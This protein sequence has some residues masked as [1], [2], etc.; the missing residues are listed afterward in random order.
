MEHVKQD[1]MVAY[2][3]DTLSGDVRVVVEEHLYNCDDCMAHYLECLE[4]EAKDIAMNESFTDKTMTIMES[5]YPTVSKNPV[6]SNTKN[7]TIVHYILA[8]SLTL[9]L[10]MSGVFQN[11]L[12]ITDGPKMQNDTPFTHKIMDRTS[13]FLD[14]WLEEGR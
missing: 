12:S 6:Y 2:I 10:V 7:K 9:I 11:A 1:E 3:S 4:Q 5:I 8:A 13:G 14:K